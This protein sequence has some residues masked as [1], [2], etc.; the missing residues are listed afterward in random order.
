MDFFDKITSSL[1][2]Y[3]IVYFIFLII[4]IGLGIIYLNKLDYLTISSEVPLTLKKDT[5]I[6]ETDLPFVKG[7]I[8]PP[9]DIKKAGVPSPEL[10][11]KGKTQFAALCSGCHGMEGKG[12][13]PAGILLNPKPRNFHDLNGW[14]NGTKIS[15]MYKTMQEGI[16]NRGMASFNYLPPIDRF[17][18][19]HYIRT[20]RPDYPKESESELTELDKTYSLSAGFKQPNQIPVSLALEKV[21]SEY[22][23]VE[24]KVNSIALSIENETKDTGAVIF[25]RISSNIQ[26]S[27]RVLNSNTLWSE[28]ENEFV[29]LIETDPV[30]NGYKTTVYELSPQ[31]VNAVYRYLRD[32]FSNY[33]S[34]T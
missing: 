15:Q 2:Y 10:I 27:V 23:P 5:V 28:N 20:L 1:K 21:L 7:E 9:V 22:N 26:K 19:I 33:K 11:E 25:K 30:Y 16:V 13:G 24:A 12:D 8:M 3:G 6:A 34:Q 32:L 29:N 14:T 18:L 17:S 4:I 31:E